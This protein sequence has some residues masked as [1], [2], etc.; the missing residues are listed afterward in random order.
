MSRRCL[1]AVIAVACWLTAATAQKRSEGPRPDEVK[2]IAYGHA[3]DKHVL[4]EGNRDGEEFK[5]GRRIAGKAFPNESITTRE[6]FAKLLQDI[7]E[8]TKSKKPSEKFRGK[9][10]YWDDRTGTFIV[11][12]P[13]NRDRGT[14]FRPFRGKKYYDDQE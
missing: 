8:K 10:Y 12:D 11:Y 14:A 6:Q 5:K 2:K 7:V 3:F 1:A 4:G 9:F 13:R